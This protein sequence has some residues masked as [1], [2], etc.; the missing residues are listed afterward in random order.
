[1]SKLR[2]EIFEKA[3]LE[4]SSDLA[5][6]YFYDYGLKL[7]DIDKKEIQKL[8]M[9]MQIEIDKLLVDE[10]YSMV[11]KLC[12]DYQVIR[13]KSGIF[14]KTNGSYFDKRE[15]ICFRKY[16]GFPNYTK[17]QKPRIEIYFCGWAS[18]CNRIPYIKGFIE[19][20]DW[21]FSEKELRK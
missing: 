4:I 17:E 10:S 6:K 2:E 12:I 16:P 20:C 8:K 1:M 3:H 7:T 18:G 11:K 13:N 5:R 21:M 14:I 9:F 15:A 19:W